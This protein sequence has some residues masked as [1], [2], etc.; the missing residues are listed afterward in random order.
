MH[1]SYRL[2][3]IYFTLFGLL[4]LMSGAILFVEKLGMSYESISLFYLGSEAQ[5]T[6]PKSTFGLLE[7]ALP[8]LGAMGLFVFVIGHFLLFTPKKEKARAIVPVVLLFIAALLD[9]ISGFI[10]I[11]GWTFFIWI[12]LVSFFSLQIIG[13]YLLFL[14]FKSALDS[15]LKYTKR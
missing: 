5:F 2:A 12:K 13:L 10:I 14:V 11:Q 8:H 3:V 7:T 15:L 9:I 6:Q 1:Q 4:L